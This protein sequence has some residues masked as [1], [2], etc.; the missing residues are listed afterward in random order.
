[1]AGE[2]T[3]MC[4]LNFLLK[5]SLLISELFKGDL[6]RHIPILYHVIINKIGIIIVEK[7]V[8]KYEKKRE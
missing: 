8:V 5:N 3:T 6:V 4:S 1:M 7:I 2:S